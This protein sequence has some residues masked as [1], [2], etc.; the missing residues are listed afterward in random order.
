MILAGGAGR[1]MGRDKA[2]MPFAGTPLWRVVAARLGPQVDALAISAGGDAARIG[3]F[4]GP[5]L[6]DA[7]GPGDG[8]LAGILA[9]LRWAGAEGA[10][11]VITAPVDL[12]FLPGDYVP[13]LYLAAE[14]TGAAIAASGGRDHGACGLWPV[15]AIPALAA[16]MAAGER[17]VMAFAATL[18]PGRAAW[19]GA[20]GDPRSDPF[21]SLNTPEDLALAEARGRA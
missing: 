7:G 12:P 16:A 4:D 21:F 1:R 14:G 15:T 2:L 11:H 13:K 20:A 10:A 3:G 18:S 9:A 5:V 8:P 17:R 6:T 19:P